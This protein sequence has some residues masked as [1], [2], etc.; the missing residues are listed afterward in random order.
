MTLENILGSILATI[1]AGTAIAGLVFLQQWI[2]KQADKSIGMRVL[3]VCLTLLPALGFI[4]AGIAA[5]FID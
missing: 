3:M 2:R 1:V 4:V 5:Y